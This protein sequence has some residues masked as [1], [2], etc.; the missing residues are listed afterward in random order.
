MGD[1]KERMIYWKEWR[2]A[3]IYQ[4]EAVKSSSSLPHI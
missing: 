2:G 3:S 4:E 1:K